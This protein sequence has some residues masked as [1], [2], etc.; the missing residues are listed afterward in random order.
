M[1]LRRWLVSKMSQD[2][3]INP[4]SSDH[5]FRGRSVSTEKENSESEHSEKSPLVSTKSLAKLLF[6]KNLSSQE[7][8]STR[9]DSPTR[10]IKYSIV[11]SSNFDVICY[12]KSS[13][14]NSIK[15]KFS[16]FTF[17]LFTVQPRKLYS[18]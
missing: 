10:L 17:Q 3:T 5:N 14:S 15:S 7:S 2:T 1:F 8:G 9:D 11:R 6:N 18:F 16:P 4:F 13:C 12:V